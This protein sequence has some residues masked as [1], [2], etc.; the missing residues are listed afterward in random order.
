MRSRN[1]ILIGLVVALLGQGC[2]K[3]EEFPPEPYLEY[4]SFTNDPENA[5]MRFSFTDGD[6]NVGLS[7][8]DT[9]S[10]FNAT[11]DPVNKYHWN[12]WIRYYEKI[13]G[14]WYEYQSDDPNAPLY[15]DPN[16]TFTRIRRLDP[17]GQNKALEGEIIIDMTGWYPLTLA[18]TV[19]Y[20]V[21]L[22]DRDLNLSNEAK[23]EEIYP[24]Q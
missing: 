23:T 8:S 3:T 1:W 17:E 11:N 15:L 22:I 12:L 9:L 2:L 16:S 6:G 13:D 10:P 24:T 14:V 4:L 7:A 5:E 18:D 19:Q 21:V 20:G